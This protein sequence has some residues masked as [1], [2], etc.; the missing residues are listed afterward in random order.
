MLPF[1]RF[2]VFLAGAQLA[3]PAAAPGL[4]PLPVRTTPG[5]GKLAL[6]AGFGVAADG[7]LDPRLDAALDRFVDL[8][9]RQTGILMRSG[10]PAG[11][12]AATLQ[13]ECS[14]GA[15]SPYPALGVDESYTLDVSAGGRPDQ[16]RDD[17]GGAAWPGDLRPTDSL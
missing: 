1:F 2:L 7:C 3:A 11:A 14:G 6:D 5:P 16:G 17:L 15:A 4:M 12:F 9:S 10:R 13:V 8:V